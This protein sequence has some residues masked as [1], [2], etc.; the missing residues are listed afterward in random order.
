MIQYSAESFTT[1]MH[2]T[3][4]VIPVLENEYGNKVYVQLYER[5][6]FGSYRRWKDDES[7]ID[8][9]ADY[10]DYKNEVID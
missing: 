9:L 10:I 1:A 6:S 3:E 7:G 2:I 8:D 4:L 5:L